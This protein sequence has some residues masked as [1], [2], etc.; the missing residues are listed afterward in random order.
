MKKIEIESRVRLTQP[1]SPNERGQ[2]NFDLIKSIP[3]FQLR[4]VDIV[5]YLSLF[6]RQAKRCK[7]DLK[8]WVKS[9]L[10]LLPSEILN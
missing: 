3:K 10:I 7:I 6:E 5:I 4:E 1:P 2:Y 9:L 8:N